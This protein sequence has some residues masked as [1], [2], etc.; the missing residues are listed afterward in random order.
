MLAPEKVLGALHL[1]L[2]VKMGVPFQD[3]H[4]LRRE[5][6]SRWDGKDGLV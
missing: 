2:V 3:T 1:A 6:G 4:R 5:F